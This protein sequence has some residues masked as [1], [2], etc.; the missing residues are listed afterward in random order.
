MG[1]KR[2]QNGPFGPFLGSK[3]GHFGLILLHLGVQEWTPILAI[4]AFWAVLAPPRQKGSNGGQKGSYS[5]IIV[6]GALDGTGPDRSGS[7]RF[8]HFGNTTVR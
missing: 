1:P 8:D 3:M 2:G 7:D 5:S 6:R 4:L